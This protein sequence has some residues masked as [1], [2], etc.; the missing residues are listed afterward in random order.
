MKYHILQ[1]GLP[2]FIFF[3]SCNGKS[4]NTA[5]AQD[6][7]TTSKDSIVS[8]AK[9]SI[10]VQQPSVID[11]AEYRRL[12]KYLSNGDSSGRWPVKDP[13]PVAG[14]VLPF[15]RVVAY[16]GNLY[17]NRMGALGKWPKKE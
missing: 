12:T 1:F 4:Q 17:S 9:D 5:S 11:S 10:P 3:L 2:L 6:S 8:S 16:Y 13:I 7:I 15:N 14:A